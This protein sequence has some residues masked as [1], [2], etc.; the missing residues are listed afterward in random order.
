[1]IEFKNSNDYSFSAFAGNVF[2]YKK[3]YSN[4][5][6]KDCLWLSKSANFNNWEYV[7]VYARRTGRFLGRYYRNSF[8]PQK[9]R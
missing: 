1:M 7:N 6:Y 2:L 4:N 3:D 8:I 5:I 9:P